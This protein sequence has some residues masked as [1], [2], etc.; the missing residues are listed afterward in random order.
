MTAEGNT[1]ADFPADKYC[2]LVFCEQCGRQV[3]LD[4][5]Q[6]PAGT[7]VQSLAGPLRRSRWL[8]SRWG[9]SPHAITLLVAA[10][11][12]NRSLSAVSR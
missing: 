5:S 4:R 1:P 8:C 2:I 9:A 3:I 11:A 12:C 10:T 7:I 6:V